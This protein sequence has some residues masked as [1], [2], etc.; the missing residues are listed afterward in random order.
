MHFRIVINENEKFLHTSFISRAF[1]FS[2]SQLSQDLSSS[3]FDL[4]NDINNNEQFILDYDALNDEKMIN[5]EKVINDEEMIN[6]EEV[7][8]DEKVINDEEVINDEKMIND[9]EVINDDSTNFEDSLIDILI[10]LF[11]ES[12][13]TTHKRKTFD[14]LKN[15]F[16]FKK[17]VVSRQTMSIVISSEK[18]S[19]SE[20]DV[21][22]KCRCIEMKSL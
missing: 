6:D 13:T 22:E 2:I 10:S 3:I 17:I 11:V 20:N 14:K 5:D 7:I 18:I 15:R 8:N 4:S 12:S 16:S 19:D 21:D 9:E 1:S